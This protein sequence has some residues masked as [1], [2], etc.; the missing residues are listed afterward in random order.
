MLAA[1]RNFQG[2]AQDSPLRRWRRAHGLTQASLAQRCSVRPDTVARW[3]Q[4]SRHPLGEALVRLME[5]TELPAEA[6]LFP[7]RYLA[8]HPDYLAAWGS[9][10][11]RRGRPR[12]QPPPEEG[13]R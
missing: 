9:A 2:M 11:P 8:A 7:A 6:L 3:E 1:W 13:H 4:G 10:P 12:K 5:L